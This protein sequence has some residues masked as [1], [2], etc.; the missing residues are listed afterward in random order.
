[1]SALKLRRIDHVIHTVAD[2]DKAQATFKELGFTTTPRADHPF[3]T[4]QVTVQL[5]DDTYIEL[6]TV[7]APEKL[8][9]S[10]PGK[11][12]F[13][14][15]VDQF[16]K[17]K[18]GMSGLVFATTDA[19]KEYQRMSSAGSIHAETFSFSRQAEQP[20]GTFKTVSF[21]G[22]TPMLEEWPDALFFFCHHLTPSAMR[23]PAFRQHKNGAS[24]IGL[25]LG[26]VA[27]PAEVH[28]TLSDMLGEKELD[29]TSFGI[30]IPFEGALVRFLTPEGIKQL[31]GIDVSAGKTPSF[32][33]YGIKIAGPEK[34]PP[35]TLFGS[36][37]FF[38]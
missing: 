32:V 7:E 16:L 30:D 21:S 4:V 18:E 1:M 17:R 2:L 35:Q 22:C 37:L 36:S 26:T 19:D 6:V 25:I 24:G 27:E 3:G 9:P 28:E 13:P 20:D 11:V 15:H 34:P 23:P 38:I 5:P 14:L 12:F 33:G 10:E 29:A 31:Y 8:P